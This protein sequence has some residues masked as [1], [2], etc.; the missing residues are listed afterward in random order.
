MARS[1]SMGHGAWSM[2]LGAEPMLLRENRALRHPYDDESEDH[3]FHCGIRPR[4]HRAEGERRRQ[5][6]GNDAG[7]EEMVAEQCEGHG[8]KG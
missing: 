1:K 3:N 4:L 6:Q 7:G 8:A 5:D 2:E